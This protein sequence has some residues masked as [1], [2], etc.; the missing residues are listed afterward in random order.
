MD[1]ALLVNAASLGSGALSAVFWVVAAVVKAPPPPGF[2]GKPDGDYW[3]C[4]IL[5]GG[6]LLGTLRLQSKW[7]SRAAFAAAAAVALQVTSNLM[8]VA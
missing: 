5:N 2:E 6:E 1:C 4:S 8:G 3:K 7:N